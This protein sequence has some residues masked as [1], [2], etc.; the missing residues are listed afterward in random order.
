VDPDPRGLVP[1]YLGSLGNRTQRTVE[2]Y[3]QGLRYLAAWCA[4]QGMTIDACKRGDIQRYLHAWRQRK[5]TDRTVGQY[6]NTARR[7]YE[8]AVREG[9][10]PENPAVGVVAKEVRSPPRRMFVSLNDMRRLVAAGVSEHPMDAAVVLLVTLLGLNLRELVGLEVKDFR[11]TSTGSTLTTRRGDHSR[12][13]D[14]PPLLASI[15]DQVVGGRTTGPLLLNRWD[16]P[17]TGASL[18]RVLTRLCAKV[19]VGP[20]PSVRD[21]V[22]STRHIAIS[23]GFSFVEVVSAMSGPTMTTLLHAV[24]TLP[25]PKRPASYR[26]AALLRPDHDSTAALLDEAYAL[27]YTGTHPAVRVMLAGA[28]LERHMRALAIEREAQSRLPNKPGGITTWTGPLTGAGVLSRDESADCQYVA[29]RR[30][31]AAHGYFDAIAEHIA[32]DVLARTQSLIQAHPL[33]ENV[34]PPPVDQREPAPGPPA[35]TPRQRRVPNANVAGQSSDTP[36]H[37]RGHRNAIPDSVKM[38]VWRRDQGRCV[39]CATNMNLEYDHIIPRSM[40]GSDTARNIQLLCGSCN[41]TKG[42]RLV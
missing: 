16:A 41:R 20:A 17:V 18:N 31:E 27:A 36:Q 29:D 2:T 30:N 10:I 3:E 23:E 38:F 6:G 34:P 11:R 8:W 39:R 33:G 40:G 28:V 32:E 9:L 25:P 14:L 42:A 22:A 19:G 35:R 12:T 13:H 15:L 26:M 24:S 21:L 7:F 37:Q 5:V 4:E 1:A